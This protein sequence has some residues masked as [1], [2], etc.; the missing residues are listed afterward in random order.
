ML[1]L[2]TKDF[3]ALF[4]NNQN[5]FQNLS[6][7]SKSKAHPLND[8]ISQSGNS[9]TKID[10]KEETYSS[11]QEDLKRATNDTILKRIPV[12]A[13]ATTVL[14][15]FETNLYFKLVAVKLRYKF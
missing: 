13:E 3:F 6:N 14:V 2:C 7:D 4:N 10:M 5:H 1:L 12:G 11:S 8:I 15:I 9:D